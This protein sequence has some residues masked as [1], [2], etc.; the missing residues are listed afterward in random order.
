MTSAITERAYWRSPS[1]ANGKAPR[2]LRWFCSACTRSP[3]PW[4]RRRT[5][6]ISITLSPPRPERQ[7]PGFQLWHVRPESA[8]SVTSGPRPSRRPRDGPTLDDPKVDALPVSYTHLRAHETGRNLVCR[9]LL[10]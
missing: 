2:A 9:L 5:T 3:T 8:T 10:E 7:Q 4:C 1:P 6:S